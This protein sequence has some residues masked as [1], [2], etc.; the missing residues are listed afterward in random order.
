MVFPKRVSL[1]GSSP[2]LLLS[3]L[4]VSLSMV[5]SG[6]PYETLSHLSWAT[7]SHSSGCWSKA[8]TCYDCH[9]AEYL[10]CFSIADGACCSSSPVSSL[11]SLW[12]RHP[13]ANDAESRQLLAAS[14]K[15]PCSPRH[16][17]L[18]RS[19]HFW[20]G[21]STARRGDERARAGPA[22]YTGPVTLSVLY[23]TAFVKTLHGHHTCLYMGVI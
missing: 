21:T 17:G 8:C 1:L 5:H 20:P 13:K 16:D 3:L 10:L 18:A 4:W 11:S 19:P 7:L 2:L 6:C 15:C 14:Y 9:T 23:C 22:R 12:R